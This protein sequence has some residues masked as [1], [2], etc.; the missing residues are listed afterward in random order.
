MSHIALQLSNVTKRFG[1]HVALDDVSIDIPEGTICGLVGP[2]GAGKTTA[3]SVIAGFLKPDEGEVNILGDGE[4]DPYSFKGRLGVLPQDA[5]LPNRHTPRA[6]L[7]HLA[8]LQGLSKESARDESRQ[9]LTRVGLEDRMDKAIHTLSHGMQ[10][11][12]AVA[13]ALVG[14]PDLVLLDEPLA[15]LDPRQAG[16]V[17]SALAELRGIK[18]LIVSSH[19]LAE[20]ERLCD[21]VVMMD[22]GKIVEQGPMADVTGRGDVIRWEIGERE[23]SLDALGARLPNHSFLQNG[24]FLEQQTPAQCDIDAVTLVVMQHLVDAGISVRS[25]SRG[26]SL[27]RAFFD[28]TSPSPPV[29]ATPSDGN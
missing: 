10:R 7:M 5:I 18:T 29:S 26:Q 2:N 1:E 15:G 9:K 12:V 4:F 24:A 8:Q 17:R 25:L 22:H 6:L 16:N 21:W 28:S 11:R 27:E 3:F 13:T 14:N 23:V 19:N 20:L